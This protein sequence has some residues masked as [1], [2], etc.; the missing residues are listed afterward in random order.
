MIVGDE[1]ANKP[2]GSA[3]LKTRRICEQRAILGLGISIG[4]EIT[5]DSV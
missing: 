4:L 1:I 2:C 5:D 3:Q